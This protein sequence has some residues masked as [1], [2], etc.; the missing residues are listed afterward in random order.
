MYLKSEWISATSVNPITSLY[1]R[2]T[3]ELVPNVVLRSG[4]LNCVISTRGRLRGTLSYGESNLSCN[5]LCI[6]III[7]QIKDISAFI[8]RHFFEIIYFFAIW[9]FPS[10]STSNESQMLRKPFWIRSS[11][12]AW[13]AK[14]G[15]RYL[16]MKD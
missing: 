5:N 9:H 2:G 15:L 14:Y 4:G 16:F 12:S 1:G 11:L 13:G 7:I 10:F 3:G 8:K 6:K